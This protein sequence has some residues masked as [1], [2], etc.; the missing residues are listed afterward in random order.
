MIERADRYSSIL[1]LHNEFL[2]SMY[3]IIWQFEVLPERVEEFERVYGSQGEWAGLFSRASGYMGTTLSRE[4]ESHAMYVTF[5]YWRTEEDF[6]RFSAAFQEAYN[7]LD[8]YCAPLTLHQRRI[9][10]FVMDD[11]HP[12]DSV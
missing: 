3:V 8:R 5:D 11:V 6:I 2:F 10:A 1:L 7:V 9:G 12:P 4:T